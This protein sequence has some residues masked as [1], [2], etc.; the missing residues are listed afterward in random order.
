MTTTPKPSTS[1]ERPIGNAPPMTN[2]SARPTDIRDSTGVQAGDHN[3]QQII[4]TYIAQQVVQP[5]AERTGCVVVGEVPQRA[6]AF[7]SRPHLMAM[8][9]NSGPGI[10]AVR[11]VTGM[12]GVGKTQLAAAYA[13]A[14]ID[15]RWQLV[16]WVNAADSA[17]IQRGLADTATALGLGQPGQD[18]ADL[19]RAVRHWLEANGERCLVVFDNATDLD[20]LTDFIPAAG[21]CQIAITSSQEGTVGL[22]TAVP[23]DVFTEDEAVEFLVRRSRQPA[24][25]DAEA[26]ASELGFLPLALAQAAAVI[27]TQ[28]LTYVT[29]LERLRAAPVASYLRRV[30]GEPYPHG[31]A[32]AVA[33]AI[34][35][36]VQADETGL[37]QPLIDLLALLAETGT[38]RTLLHAAGQLGV[39]KRPER[40]PAEPAAVD[41]ALGHLASRSLVTFSLDASTVTLH[42]LTARVAR[43]R[44]ANNGNLTTMAVAATGLLL[45]VRIAQGE[46][47]RN[48]PAARDIVGQIVALHQHI[49]DQ[50]ISL[51]PTQVAVMLALRG[52]AVYCLNELADSIAQTISYGAELLIDH[53]RILGDGH[54]ETQTARNNLAAA[55]WAAGRLDDA[56]PL[57]ERTLADREQILGQTDPHTLT[58]RNNLAMAYQTAGRLDDAVPLHERTLCDFEQTK[59]ETHPETLQS[60]NNLATAYQSAGRTDDAIALLERVL[61]DREQALGDSHPDTL[62]SRNN[63]AATYELAGRLDDAILMHERVLTDFEQT[64]G[65]THP[66]TLTSRNNLAM[67]YQTAGR[68][69]DAIPL[70]E[71]VLTD[72][73][74]TLGDAHPHFLGARRNLAAAYLSA[75]RLD[76]AIPLLSGIFTEEPTEATGAGGGE[77]RGE[78]RASPAVLDEAAEDRL[79]HS[80]GPDDGQQGNN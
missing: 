25:P 63:L 12:R 31:V 14:C 18:L 76:D 72:F 46:P 37:S 42:R 71:R 28:R 69:D 80:V 70:H 33:M 56:I 53:V 79:A 47:W 65:H 52:W 35:S 15:A 8:L 21:Q 61:A 5:A 74:Q 29:Y 32:E 55:Y 58:T 30:A 1:A 43:E 36:A 40:I 39:L 51:E 24:G 68:L 11:A 60:R 77:G 7:Q 64:L 38:S 4:K 67:A 13:R 49:T 2:Q 19:G 23:V 57:L 34:D 73:E 62:Q 17:Q 10:A 75:G 78:G 45:A 22:G 48:R 26:L 41:E 16:T 54:P 50:K 66:H 6:P 27:A 9:E 20:L 44:A 3:T 59:G